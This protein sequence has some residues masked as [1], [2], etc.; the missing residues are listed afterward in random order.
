MYVRPPFTLPIWVVSMARLTC[1]YCVSI[2]MWNIWVVSMARVPL[3][4]LKHSVPM[5]S[6]ANKLSRVN[7]TRAIDSSQTHTVCTHTTAKYV[8][9][10]QWHA[11]HWLISTQT[12]AYV[13]SCSAYCVCHRWILIVQ[14]SCKVSPKWYSIQQTPR[15]CSYIKGGTAPPVHVA[16]SVSCVCHILIYAIKCCIT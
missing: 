9:S 3:T 5:R 11:C 15:L 13:L 2:I 8:E 14:V 16:P 7:G 12:S 4:H 10:C 1:Y 6:T